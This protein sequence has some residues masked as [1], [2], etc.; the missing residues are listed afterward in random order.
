MRRDD[1]VRAAAVFMGTLF[2]AACS[3]GQTA[4][5]ASVQENPAAAETVQKEEKQDINSVHLR[6]KELLYADE[7]DTG[8]I[9][10]YLTV[11]RGNR[12][13]N[14]DHSWEEINTYSAYDYEDMGVARYQVAGLLQVGDENGP[15]EGEVGYGETVPNATV[16]IRGQTSSRNAQKNYKIE[17]KKNKGTWNGQRTINLN[18]HQ[19]DGLR[20]RNKLMYELIQGIPQL[21]GLRTQFVHLYV[22]DNTDGKEGEFVDYGLYT[23][24]E[25]L[26]K[27]ALKAHGLDSNAQ[28]YKVNFFEFYRYEEIIKTEDDPDFNKERFE[29]ML[30]I[31][32]DTDHSKLIEMLDVLN[33]YSVPIDE[34]LDQYFDRENLMYWLA[35]EILTGN[36]DTQSR[37]VYLYSPQNSDIWYLIPWDHDGAFSNTEYEIENFAGKGSWESGISNY[38]GNVLFQRCLK[39]KAFREQL[40]EVMLEMKEYLSRDRIREL[41]ERYA[42]VVKPYVYTMPDRMYAGLTP[43]E[44]DR[45]AAAIPD[46]V[47]ENYQMYL[48]SLEKPQPFYIGTPSA[49]DGKLRI[50]WDA[51]FDFD[52]EDITYTVEVAKD[53]RFGE[54]IF[55]A[56]DLSIPEVTLDLPE[57][58]Q[59]FVRVRATNESGMTQD[60]FDYYV[61]DEGKHF[62]IKCFYVNPDQTIGEDV[63]EE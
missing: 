5:E 29:G 63:Y 16:Q 12:A 53:Y 25:Q 47:E 50:V 52:A 45:V 13:E 57:T 26:N 1:I 46:E 49:E 55:E 21:I 22:K 4:E 32:G 31:K 6:D 3:A 44:Y 20:F 48:E 30:E 59:Y 35:F 18:K 56:Q 15:I 19:A 33:D 61:T 8:V 54:K 11:S 27:T 34:V 36:V 40:H 7:D 62:G 37:N 39:S 28:L 10:M 9:T 23:Q 24:V 43:E 38:W 42:A 2:L 60:A 17:L 51:S 41:A 14:T 58:G